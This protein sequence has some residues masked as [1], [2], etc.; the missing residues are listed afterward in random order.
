V[1]AP[2]PSPA[3]PSSL[4]SPYATN[5]AVLANSNP[6]GAWSLFI[7]DDTPFNSGAVSNGWWLNLITADT[8]AGNADLGISSFAAP[9]S[10]IATSNLTYTIM[11]TN[12]G[13]SAAANVSV[14]DTLPA[15]S[16]LLSSNASVGSVSVSGEVLTWAIR[17]LAKDAYASLS[18]VLQP[19]LAGTITNMAVV[20][21]ATSDL[22]PEDDTDLNVLT[23]LSPTADL[24]LALGG[25][26]NPVV[27]GKSV[28]YTMTITNFGPATAP[29]V[30][31]TDVLPSGVIFVSAAPGGYVLNNNIIT[32]TNLGDLGSGTQVSAQVV[33]TTVEGGTITNTASTSSSVIDPFKVNNTASIKTEVEQALISVTQSGNTLTISWPA[34][35]GS[36]VLEFTTSLQ[37]PINWAP[38]TSPAPTIGGGMKTV[39]LPVGGGT[40]FFRLHGQT[41]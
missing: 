34:D 23:V 12:Y 35:F 13:P 8:I 15:N 14:T 37:P 2:F 39:V 30:T 9:E 21:S 27:N 38:V 40:T 3:P 19:G 29:T 16:T 4:S 33:V 6:N 32:F 10:P 26:P 24:A 7:V 28:T 5:L 17:T 22:N 20:D 1:P 11:V 31:L 36:Y 25:A 18:F 41:P